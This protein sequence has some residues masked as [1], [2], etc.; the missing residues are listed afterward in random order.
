MEQAHEGLP[1]APQSLTGRPVRST[2]RPGLNYCIADHYSDLFGTGRRQ[3]EQRC[4]GPSTLPSQALGR[5]RTRKTRPQLSESPELSPLKPGK[6]SLKSKGPARPAKKAK[7]EN[8]VNKPPWSTL[9]Y[10]ILFSIFFNLSPFTKENPLADVSQLVKCLLGLSRMC[11]AFFEPAVSAL[12]F[13]PPLFPIAKAKGLLELLKKDQ[14]TLFI[15]YRNKVRYL[16]MDS[17]GVKAMLIY[18]LIKHTPRLRHLR[19]CDLEEYSRERSVARNIPRWLFC[20][21]PQPEALRNLRLHSWEWNS[22]VTFPSIKTVHCHPAFTSLRSV[23]FF[24]LEHHGSGRQADGPEEIDYKNPAVQADEIASALSLLPNLE[25]LEFK[26]CTFVRDLLQLLPRNLDALSIINCTDIDSSVVEEFL[27][28]HGY[29]LRELAFRHNALLGM[30]FAARLSE[31]CPHLRSFVMDFN[32]AFKKSFRNSYYHTISGNYDHLKSDDVPPLFPPTLQYLE[33][34]YMRKWELSA[35]KN[36]F[37]SIIDAAPHLCELRTLIVTLIMEVD[38]R[39][40]AV[41]R[42]QWVKKLERVFLRDSPPPSRRVSIAKPTPPPEPA[43]SSSDTGKRRLSC[44]DTAPTRR[45]K[46]LAERAAPVR[47]RISDPDSE[48]ESEDEY[49]A[50][51]EPELEPERLTLPVDSEARQG[52]CNVV[53]I[54]I[55]NLRP[56]AVLLSAENISDEESDDTDWDGVDAEID[57]TYAW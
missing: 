2:R 20:D 12:Y 39:D 54:R 44:D 16:E 7:L 40:R 43:P 11:R 55:D 18:S 37:N 15:N 53:K 48:Q 35:A 45:S 14:D 17:Y 8:N 9:P 23:R 36:F 42:D 28:T 51:P 6:R 21:M 38:W 26:Q 33:L 4:D 31:F 3:R 19:L 47:Y 22:E 10:H 56:G 25:R 13:S 29:H 41:F 50:E 49:L 1:P 32:L 52:M 34:Q 27:S 24:R 46:R 57:D 30:S 5:T